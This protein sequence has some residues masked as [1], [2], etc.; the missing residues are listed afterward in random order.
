MKSGQASM[1]QI[2]PGAP[3]SALERLLAPLTRDEFFAQYWE[4]LPLRIHRG[5]HQFFHYLIR[6]EELGDVLTTACLTQ[7]EAV[8][9][10]GEAARAE[11][12]GKRDSAFSVSAAFARGVTVRLLN[13]QRFHPPLWK[14]TRDLESLLSFPVR[15][16]LYWTPPQ[17]RGLKRHW[18]T[19]DVMVL[20]IAGR[21][22]WRILESPAH[23]PLQSPPPLPFEDTRTLPQT[24]GAVPSHEVMHELLAQSAVRDELTLEQGDLLYLP[25]GV[26]HE[27]WTSEQAS[28]HLTVGLHVLTWTDLLAV[29]LGQV[30]NRD[31]RFRK[32]LPP[33]FAAET[34][35]G[36]VWH[37]Q[38][39]ELLH[40]LAQHW[41][42]TVASEELAQVFIRTRSFVSGS[43]QVES[44]KTTPL[45]SETVVRRRPGLLAHLIVKEQA[46][47]LYFGH[48]TFAAPRAMETALRF[49]AQTESFPIG[50]IPGGLNLRNQCALVRQLL[51][52]QFLDMMPTTS[53]DYFDT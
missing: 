31:E 34:I 45:Q 15:I 48:G 2:N 9:F 44:Q 41:D 20:Q 8:E 39:Q 22:H 4:H 32:A 35:P 52:Q 13:A 28:A 42:L 51:A 37:Q 46:V 36:E 3:A 12:K 38:A 26:A 14:L 27:A 53:A 23:L 50:A 7:S 43:F 5:D 16:N 11:T 24:R 10:L 21:K 40:A 33:G 25:R 18:D 47:S 1:L 19:H 30:A 17:Q 6:P 29:A 49:I